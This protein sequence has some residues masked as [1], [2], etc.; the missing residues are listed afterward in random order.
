MFGAKPGRSL[1]R[2][3]MKLLIEIGVVSFI[4]LLSFGDCF[5]TYKGV[6]KHGIGIEKNYLPKKIM[7][8]FGAKAIF[9]FQIP[10]VVGVIIAIILLMP[11][12]LI[13]YCLFAIMCLF[14]TPYI[15][16]VIT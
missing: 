2:C 10:V 6:L 16:L 4:I 12:S 7:Q 3:I 13:V 11:Q 15:Y 9:Y 14:L 5:L 8:K 1:E